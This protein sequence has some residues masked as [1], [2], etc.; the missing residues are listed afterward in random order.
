[1]VVFWINGHIASW[2]DTSKYIRDNA[3]KPS[4][5]P[6]VF[7]RLGSLKF[8]FRLGPEPAFICPGCGRITPAKTSSVDHIIPKST[9]RYL[10]FKGSANDDSFRFDGSTLRIKETGQIDFR[11]LYLD[12]GLRKHYVT[13]HPDNGSIDYGQ[14]DYCTS[15]FRRE[16]SVAIEDIMIN[17][18]ENLRL[19]CHS[20]N[21]SKG[22]R[23]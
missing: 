16:G 21:S 2:T 4:V 5:A 23:Y 9:F 11:D 18:L 6:Y 13:H 19:M 12:K 15:T 10:I 3:G 22:N 7:D 17:A 8:D 20:C 1:M 14:I